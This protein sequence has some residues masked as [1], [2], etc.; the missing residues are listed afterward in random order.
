VLGANARN[1][2]ALKRNDVGTPQPFRSKALCMKPVHCFTE[3]I[4]EIFFIGSSLANKTVTMMGV[5]QS[6][7]PGCVDIC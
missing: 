5:R 2:F 3:K 6:G 1:R 7:T 4:R